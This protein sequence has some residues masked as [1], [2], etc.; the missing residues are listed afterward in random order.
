MTLLTARDLAARNWPDHLAE[1]ALAR[2]G[3]RIGAAR[4]IHRD[5]VVRIEVH[6]PDAYKL[7]QPAAPSRAPSGGRREARR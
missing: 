2:L 6:G 5:H 7:P 3:E 1:T 4:V